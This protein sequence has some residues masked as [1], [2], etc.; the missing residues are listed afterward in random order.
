MALWRSLRHVTESTANQTRLFYLLLFFGCSFLPEGAELAATLSWL[1]SVAVGD[2]QL[3][4]AV[5]PDW[6]STSCQ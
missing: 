6:T 4:F 1:V 2:K 3:V 5:G